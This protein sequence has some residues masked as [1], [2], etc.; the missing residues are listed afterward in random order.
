[1]FTTKRSVQVKPPACHQ[2][3]AFPQQYP[4]IP[5]AFLSPYYKMACFPGEEV[6]DS[7]IKAVA[8]S[9]IKAARHGARKT[10]GTFYNEK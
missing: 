1:M 3:Q 4:S 5:H 10:I 7:N 6:A 9:I 2:V 8:E